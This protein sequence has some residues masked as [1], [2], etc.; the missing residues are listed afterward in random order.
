MDRKSGTLSRRQLLQYGAAAATKLDVEKFFEML[1][2]LPSASPAL[3]HVV[4][5]ILARD[6]DKVDVR[7]D[8]VY[9]DIRQAAALGREMTV[10]LPVANGT[11]ELL[12]LCARP[13]LRES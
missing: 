10:P 12:Q 8:I 6:F 7:L 4:P 2:T 11:T 3:I 1:S 13:W 9:K 5:K